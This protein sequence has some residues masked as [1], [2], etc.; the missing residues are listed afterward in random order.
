M[1]IGCVCNQTRPD[2]QAAKPPA[3][4]TILYVPVPAS[5]CPPCAG[6][7]SLTR[8][9]AVSHRF[10]EEPRNLILSM[11]FDPFQP[12]KDDAK[13]SCCAQLVRI[14]NVPQQKR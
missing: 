9:N 2:R 3:W 14:L 12:F 6:I 7:N 13:Y 1:K 10:S 5:S 11:F 8:H 4:I